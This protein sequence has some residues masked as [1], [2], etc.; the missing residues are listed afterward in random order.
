MVDGW[1]AFTHGLHASFAERAV[2]HGEFSAA[3]L[4]D[5]AGWFD[6]FIARFNEKIPRTEIILWPKLN[7]PNTS[8]PGATKKPTATAR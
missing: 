4:I 1:L 2:H 8:I 6:I 3:R 5:S 7:P